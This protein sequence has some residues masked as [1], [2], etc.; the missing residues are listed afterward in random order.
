LGANQYAGRAVNPSYWLVD[1]NRWHEMEDRLISN[2]FVR[3]GVSNWEADYTYGG[4]IPNKELAIAYAQVKLSE[5][6]SPF[7]PHMLPQ[8]LIDQGQ[9][10]YELSFRVNFLNFVAARISALPSLGKMAAISRPC[11]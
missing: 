4:G 10:P 3:L 1:W 11:D 7:T 8:C 5:P 2:G 6:I 9:L